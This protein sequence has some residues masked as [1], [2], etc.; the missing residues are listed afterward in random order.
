MRYSCIYKQLK[1]PIRMSFV[2]A[3]LKLL[4]IAIILQSV[5]CGAVVGE[6]NKI[7]V[8]VFNYE[9]LS[10]IHE[11]GTISGQHIDMME[12]IALKQGWELEYIP[13]TWE[14]NLENLNTGI[15]DIVL[16]VP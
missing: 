9:P 12:S 5:S 13:S 6:D 2:K 8:G 7:N 1:P 4:I 16:A 14:K 10:V 11:N 3:T 15:V